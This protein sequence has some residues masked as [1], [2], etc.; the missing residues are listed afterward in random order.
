MK[1][2]VAAAMLSVALSCANPEDRQAHDSAEPQYT[3]VNWPWCEAPIP[4]IL[5]SQEC[6]AHRVGRGIEPVDVC[7]LVIGLRDWLRSGEVR[8]PHAYPGDYQHI[9]S[10][11]ICASG[12]ATPLE[13]LEQRGKARTLGD[14][15]TIVVRANLREQPA[16]FWASL[17]KVSGETR[18]GV[19]SE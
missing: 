3:R 13:T 9:D 6:P 10:I 4:P 11:L 5:D 18:Y 7:D 17:S 14:E 15:P 12:L 1:T 8:T 2:P 16:L 19:S